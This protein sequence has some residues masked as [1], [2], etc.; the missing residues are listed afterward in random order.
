MTLMIAS[1][2]DNEAIYD[3]CKNHFNVT[4]PSFTNLNRLI[5]QVISFVTACLR[6]DGSFNVDLNELQTNLIP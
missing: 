5:V 2:I 6:L 3:I 1:Q 4:Q